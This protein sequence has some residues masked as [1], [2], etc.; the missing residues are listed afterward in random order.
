M[1]I[2]QVMFSD[3]WGGAERLYVELCAG[4]GDAGH[5]ILSI[6][7]PGFKRGDALKKTANVT[8]KTVIA[9]CNWDYLSVWQLLKIIAD[10]KPDV[11]HA[12]L[13]RASWMVGIVGRW[14]NIPT[15]AITHNRIKKKYVTRID[16]FTTI[17]DELKIYINQ[18]GVDSHRIKKIPNFSSLAPVERVVFNGDNPTVFVSLGR[19]VEKKGFDVLLSA[20]QKF[21]VK[22]SGPAFLYLAGDGPLC[23]SLKRLASELGIE[24]CVKFIGWIDDIVSFYDSGD[25][26]V[27]PSRDEPFG[28]VLLEAMARGKSIISTNIGGPRDFLDSS[29]AF[30]VEPDDSQSLSEAMLLAVTD[31]SLRL[32]KAEKALQLFCAQYTKDAVIPEFISFYEY[33]VGSS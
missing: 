19:F 20:F 1:R 26:F 12:H 11:I 18:I 27:L 23:E 29:T 25:I 3:G 16:Y 24:H 8:C 9:C 5:D 33:V 17:T 30:L 31:Q 15:I 14:L 28:I 21:I 13:S 22:S 32:R 7:K 4:L 10:F 6:C 2:A